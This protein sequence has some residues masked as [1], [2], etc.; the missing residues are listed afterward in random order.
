MPETATNA[1][2][3]I[4]SHVEIVILGMASIF[5]IALLLAYLKHFPGR[6]EDARPASSGDGTAESVST[7]PR[8]ELRERELPGY[9]SREEGREAR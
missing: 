4:L 5:I 6:V 8:Y 9:C 3:S 1:K 7:L 2:L